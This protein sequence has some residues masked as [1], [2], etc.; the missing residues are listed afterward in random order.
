MRPLIAII[1]LIFLVKYGAEG[2]WRGRRSPSCHR[3]DCTVSQWSTWG[4]CSHRC[5]NSGIQSRHRI[6]TRDESC[7]GQCHYV[8]TQSR[9][10]NR[11]ACRNGGTPQE[12]YCSCPS[13]WTGTCCEQASTRKND[14]KGIVSL[15]IKIYF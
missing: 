9:S 8:F 4:H 6:K 12:S 2:W 1:M 10:C 7:G 5:G 13:G 11:N 15:L 14:G 3:R